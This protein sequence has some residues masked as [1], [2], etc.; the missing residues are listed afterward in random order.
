MR[1]DANLSL[2]G[3]EVALIVNGARQERAP[4]K[5]DDNAWINGKS[6]Q[7]DR[8]WQVRNVVLHGADLR[9]SLLFPKPIM[10]RKK[11]SD[12]NA[13]SRSTAMKSG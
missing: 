13:S 11:W 9:K 4:N 10:A 12:S 7:S 5:A 8:V 3:D 1:M 2:C 6:A